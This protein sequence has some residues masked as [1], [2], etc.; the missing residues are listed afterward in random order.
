VQANQPEFEAFFDAARRG[1][2]SFPRCRAC[3]RFH[4]YPMKRCPHCRSEAVEWT[5]V[6]GRGTLYSWTVV[7]HPFDDAKAHDL[8]YIVA[9]VEFPDA[10]GIRLVTN[11]VGIDPAAPSIGMPLDAVYPAADETPPLVRFR[12]AEP[13]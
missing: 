6:S 1:R 11:L 8:P 10:P 7:R 13:A 5:P 12:P 3:G 4:W 9:L 2:L